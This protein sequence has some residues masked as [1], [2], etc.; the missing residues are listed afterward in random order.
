[1]SF[2]KIITFRDYSVCKLLDHQTLEVT[3]IRPDGS[4]GNL[5]YTFDGVFGHET[6]QRDIFDQSVK[7]IVEGVM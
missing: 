7:S 2:C 1:M 5:K 3:G 4:R 6:S